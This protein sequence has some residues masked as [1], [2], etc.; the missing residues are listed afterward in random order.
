[1]QQTIYTSSYYPQRRAED[2][3]VASERT[4]VTV[5]NYCGVPRTLEHS[6]SGLV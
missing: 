5:K 3:E 6:Y 2:W 4:S 1:M